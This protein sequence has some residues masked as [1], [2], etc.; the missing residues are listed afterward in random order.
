MRNL[1]DL[2]SLIS[3]LQEI[4]AAR[5]NILVV[6]A[7]GCASVPA[8]VALDVRQHTKQARTF[9]YIE[10]AH[11]DSDLGVPVPTPAVECCDTAEIASASVRTSSPSASVPCVCVVDVGD[12]RCCGRKCPHMRVTRTSTT[13]LCF[14]ASLRKAYGPVLNLPGDTTSRWF[15]GFECLGIFGG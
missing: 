12:S 2:D 8:P 15:R 9:L 10:A 5:G 1:P 4:R 13:C 7:D 14:G 11:P 3:A 6:A